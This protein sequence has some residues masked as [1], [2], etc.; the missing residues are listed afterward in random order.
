MWMGIK[1]TKHPRNQFRL[2]LQEEFL[3]DPPMQS[4]T[5]FIGSR[6]FRK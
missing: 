3:F 6:K 2:K 4:M 5:I 1:E